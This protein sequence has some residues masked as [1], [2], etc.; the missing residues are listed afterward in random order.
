MSDIELT[1]LFPIYD[2]NVQ[3]FSYAIR[4]S[5]DEILRFSEQ[6]CLQ[7]NVENF[8]EELLDYMAIE[9]M[10]PYYDGDF[11]IKTKRELVK[12]GV[13][14]PFRAGTV[15]GVN[16]LI[17]T[18]FGNGRIVEWFDFDDVD[19]PEEWRGYFDVEINGGIIGEDSLERLETVLKRAKNE[20]RWIRK[21]VSNCDAEQKVYV[22]HDAAVAEDIVIS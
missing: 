16:Q 11:D 22:I 1:D 12:D 21:V 20:S 5:F 6:L 14:W 19:N 15:D 2:I 18:L 10:L 3:C 9:Q 4:K 7:N 8:P 17:K 13:T